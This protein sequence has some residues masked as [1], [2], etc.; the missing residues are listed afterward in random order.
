MLEKIF[1]CFSARPRPEPIT[2]TECKTDFSTYHPYRYSKSGF[3]RYRA[4]NINIRFSQKAKIKKLRKIKTEDH[5]LRNT[6]LEKNQRRRKLERQRRSE[7]FREKAPKP[8]IAKN[9]A[10]S[11]K[12]LST[13]ILSSNSIKTAKNQKILVRE[14][15]QTPIYFGKRKSP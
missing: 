12:S 7:I 3:A 4:S 1:S 13:S 11:R 2:V 10:I 14:D 6:I 9:S 5:V 8:K 15:P